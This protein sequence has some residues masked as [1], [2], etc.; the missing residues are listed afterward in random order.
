VEFFSKY[1]KALSIAVVV[2]AVLALTPIGGIVGPLAMLGTI[3]LLSWLALRLLQYTNWKDKYYWV[4]NQSIGIWAIILGALTL[5]LL[6][7]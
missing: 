4:L 5:E 7:V 2:L 3:A 6:P 1:G